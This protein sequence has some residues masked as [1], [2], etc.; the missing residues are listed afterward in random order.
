MPF[1][2]TTQIRPQI[3][4]PSL[5]GLS[6]PSFF[7]TNFTAPVSARE[8]TP[9]QPI[10][11]HEEDRLDAPRGSKEGDD[12]LEAPR[13]VSRGGVS[14]D[15]QYQEEDGP[16]ELP[17][18]MWSLNLVSAVGQ[19]KCPWG[20]EQRHVPPCLVGLISICMGLM[21]LF[22]IYLIVHDLQPD[23]RPV[24]DVKST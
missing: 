3:A 10:R 13:G 6:A 17:E 24:T 14:H 4:Q 22:T 18:N 15:G 21:Q 8:V 16:L 2:T 19:A 12:D 9:Y 20:H 5:P 23:A 1:Q 11:Q 7:W